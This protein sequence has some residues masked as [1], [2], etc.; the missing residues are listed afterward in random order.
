MNTSPATP[1]PGAPDDDLLGGYVAGMT[2]G[3]TGG[4]RG[5]WTGPAA[6][7]SMDAMVD[8]LGVTW[9]TL[10]F[11]ALQDTPQST[12]IA[13]REAPT[14][15]DDEVRTAIR[16][17]HARGLRV[18]LKPVVN[19][20][21]GTWR[22]HIAFFDV[23]VPCEPT[24]AQW[25]A[26]YTEFM[27]HYARIAAEEGVALLCVGCE[28]VQSDKREDEWRALVAAVRA[29]YD[30][31]VTYNCDKYQEGAVRWWDAVDVVSSSGYYPV[32]DWEA[33]LDRIEPVVRATG[34]PFLFLEA[35]CPSREGSP[36]LPNDW[37]LPGA[38]SGEAQR[39]W[40]EAAFAAC[41]RRDWVRGFMLWDWPTPLYPATDAATDDDYCPYAKPAET[42][43]RDAFAEASA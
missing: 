28:M 15:T 40:Y 14:P 34:K 1:P 19:V 32:D 6:D 9:V 23:D 3:W 30:G 41:A 21:N 27:T 25:F 18:C 33:Q 5:T 13:W 17:A 38:P 20:R 29:E 7:A 2:W 35:G 43:I 24:W 39:E 12:T 16:A 11:G 8:R 4:G 26:A 37:A 10:A 42:T 22:A 36:A 31:L